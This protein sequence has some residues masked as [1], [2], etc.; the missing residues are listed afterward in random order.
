MVINRISRPMQLNRFS[1]AVIF[2]LVEEAKDLKVKDNA[3]MPTSH[4]VT[5]VGK[6][7][8][9]G[10]E[11]S[12]TESPKW[13][14]KSSFLL[15]KP[16]EETVKIK[17]KGTGHGI[18]GSFILRISDLLLA[19]NLTIE[20]WHQLEAPFPQGTIWIRFELRILVPP[21]GPEFSMASSS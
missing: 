1:S 5:K 19:K 7:S 12:K 8:H 21:R 10:K 4:V 3:E 11:C 2:I 6:H 15:E 16:H 17:V 9:S 18:L 14:A 20:G 13:R